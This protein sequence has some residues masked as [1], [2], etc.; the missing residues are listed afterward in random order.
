ARVD[1]CLV[2]RVFL[3]LDLNEM[4]QAVSYLRP[5]PEMGQDEK[6]NTIVLRGI[7]NYVKNPYYIKFQRQ[8]VSLFCSFHSPSCT[9][10][11][12]ACSR[13]LMMFK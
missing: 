4:D 11:M 12:R 1:F 6:M 13:F 8:D 3:R 5:V 10:L 2:N 7:C 9:S